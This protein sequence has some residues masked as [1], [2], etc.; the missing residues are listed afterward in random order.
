MTTI[1]AAASTPPKAI[2]LLLFMLSHLLDLIINQTCKNGNDFIDTAAIFGYIGK[3]R[4]YATWR[5]LLA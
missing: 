5:L 2:C 1:A 3:K 4:R